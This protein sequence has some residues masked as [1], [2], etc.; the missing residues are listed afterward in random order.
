MKSVSS[1][2]CFSN[3]FKAIV[4]TGFYLPALLTFCVLPVNSQS[5]TIGINER[6][7]FR[8]K[9][10]QDDWQGKDVELVEALFKRLPYDYQ[11]VSMPWPRV[12]K[13]I[14]IGLIDMTISATQLPEREKYAVFS[15]HSF[16]FSHYV[17]FIN[18]DKRSLFENTHSL[19]DLI[20][21]DVTIGAL[22]GAVYSDDYYL[23]MNN[24]SFA[25]RLVFVDEDTRLPQLILKNR[26][27]AYIESEIEGAFYLSEQPKYQEQIIPLFR[28]TTE[29]DAASKLMFSKKTVPQSLIDEFDLALSD[30]HASGD[31]DRISAKYN[32]LNWEP[33]SK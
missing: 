32:L 8:Y 7:I 20:G 5:L 27:D 18:K 28:I 26:V 33:R 16:R 9:N 3:L 23:A 19:N 12:L 24:Q 6:D 2:C 14:E 10:Q 4:W 31:Y 29:R 13:S 21:V 11:L 30:L 15:N 25:S 22:R 17:L 1:R